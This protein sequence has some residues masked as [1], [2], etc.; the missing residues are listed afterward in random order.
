MSDVFLI[1]GSPPISLSLIVG[2]SKCDAKAS[3]TPRLPFFPP[4]KAYVI[5]VFNHKTGWRVGRIIC[6]YSGLPTI[7]VGN[8]VFLFC[9]FGSGVPGDRRRVRAFLGTF[10]SLLPSRNI[11]NRRSRD[12]RSTICGENYYFESLFWRRKTKPGRHTCFSQL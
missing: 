5:V 3:V 9:I 12:L 11:W 6:R 8:L 1:T 7:L 2:E 10:S 4:R